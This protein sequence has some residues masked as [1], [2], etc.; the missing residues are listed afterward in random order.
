[1]LD[2]ERREVARRARDLATRTPGR[3]GN[4]SLR[5]EDRF[6][7]T[8]SGIPYADVEPADVPVVTLAEEQVASDRMP[9]SETS[10]HAAIYR[11]LETGAVVHAHSPW[12][13]TLAALSQPV[14]PVHYALARAGGEVPVAAYATYGTEELASNAVEAMVEADTTACLLANHGVIAAGAGLDE[15]F[16]TLDSVEFTARIYAQAAPLGD[17]T[18]LSGDEI[19]HVAEQFQTYGQ[20]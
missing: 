17:P 18:V 7:V 15:A 1:M 5:A 13:T 16:E 10:M 9:S 4:L 8:P 14:P 19:N 11:G 6:A 3:S 2:D 12:A 20:R